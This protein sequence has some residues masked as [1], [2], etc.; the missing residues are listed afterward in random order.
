MR[1]NKEGAG[2]LSPTLSTLTGY[3]TVLVGSA[4]F[5]NILFSLDSGTGNVCEA[6]WR[7]MLR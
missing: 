7:Q 3:S 5:V 6:H 2:S 1:S 4:T